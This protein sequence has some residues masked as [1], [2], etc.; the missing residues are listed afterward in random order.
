MR[1]KIQK[2]LSYI[3]SKTMLI[4]TRTCYFA[5]SI[6]FFAKEGDPSISGYSKKTDCHIT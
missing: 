5:K 6:S 1:K 3:F 4:P 2:C